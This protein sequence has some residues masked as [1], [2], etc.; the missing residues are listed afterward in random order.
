MLVGSRRFD[1]F[2]ADMA[3]L[4]DASC[5]REAE[6]VDQGQRILASLVSEDS[7]LPDELARAHPEH[8]SQYMLHR[9]PAGRFTVLG[10]VWGP[11]QSA[12][13]HNHTIWGLVGQLRGA[14]ATR[15]YDDPEPGRPLRVRFEVVLRPGETT[16]VSPSLGDVHDVRNVFDGVSVSIHVYGGDLESLAPRRNRYDA[17]SGAATSFEAAYH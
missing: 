10:V 12:T 9:D 14:E 6:V 15:V 17:A 16:V 5:G 4:I 11:G 13:P 7:W 3:V 1:D 8:F 2:L